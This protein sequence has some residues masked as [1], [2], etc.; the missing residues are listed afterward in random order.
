MKSTKCDM[1][2]YKQYYLIKNTGN[3]TFFRDCGVTVCKFTP[4]YPDAYK[5]TSIF[6]IEQIM[7]RLTCEFGFGK[8]LRVIENYG[9]D[10]REISCNL[11]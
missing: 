10:E 5:T 6:T 3:N 7:R 11:S 8:E 1:S 2:I 4:E 9:G